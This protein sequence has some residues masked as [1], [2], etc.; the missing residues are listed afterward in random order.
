MKLC[1]RYQTLS[2]GL[3][4]VLG[5][6]FKMASPLDFNDPFDFDSVANNMGETCDIG[7]GGSSV[8]EVSVVGGNVR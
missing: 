3:K 1:W 8:V 6:K 7:K 2:R 4:S 5:C